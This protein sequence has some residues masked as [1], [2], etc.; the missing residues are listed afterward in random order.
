MLQN[1]EC[2]KLP[3]YSATVLSSAGW[4]PPC[5]AYLPAIMIH[6]RLF[7]IATVLPNKMS[8]LAVICRIQRCASIHLFRWLVSVPFTNT[9]HID[10]CI[11]NIVLLY[12]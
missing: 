6:L 3:S 8:L 11:H 1:E 4:T 12:E 7:L 9:R 5:V 2:Q 10:L